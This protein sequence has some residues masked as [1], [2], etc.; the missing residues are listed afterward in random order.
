M[1]FEVRLLTSGSQESYANRENSYLF[2]HIGDFVG[3]VDIME[4]GESERFYFLI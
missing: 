1:D 4:R 2:Q 3:L